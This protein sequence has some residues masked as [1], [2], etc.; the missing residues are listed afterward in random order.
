MD[1]WHNRSKSLR[2]KLSRKKIRFEGENCFPIGE[3]TLEREMEKLQ[4]LS[5]I[6]GDQLV[7]IRRAKNEISSTQRGLRVGTKNV[8]FHQRSKGGD[9]GKSRISGYGGFLPVLLRSKR[10][11]SSYFGLFSTLMVV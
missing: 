3:K 4:L 1:T 2:L 7:G 8:G 11:D 9:F 10:W 5:T 6:Y